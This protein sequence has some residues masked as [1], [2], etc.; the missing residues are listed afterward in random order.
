MSRETDIAVGGIAFVAIIGFLVGVYLLVAWAV[1][2]L[3]GAIAVHFHA[4]TI[5]FGLA[6]L[7][8]LALAL[9]AAFFKRGKK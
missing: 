2:L 3:W 1:M 9:V 7:I 5:G 4:E 8:T 6:F